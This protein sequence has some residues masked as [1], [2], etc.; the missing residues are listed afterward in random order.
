MNVNKACWVVVNK[1]KIFLIINLSF[2]GDV[3]LTNVL[4][5]NI[6]KEYPDS[7][8]VFLVNKPFQEAALF[9]S[10]VDD[11]IVMD[12]RNE[13]KGILSLMKF[14]FSSPYRNKIDASFIIYG[15]DRG[16]LL[17]YLLG[18]KKRISGPTKYT[19]YLLTDIY[20]EKD[21]FVNMQDINGN[22]IKALTGKKTE[23]LPIRYEP[24]SNSDIFVQSLFKQ[25][26]E[27]DVVALCT[28]SKQKAKDMP[29]DTAVEIIDKLNAENKT[30]F[31]FGAGQESREFADNLKKRGCVNFVDFTNITSINQLA[32]SLKLCKALISVD[33]G[34]MHLA[35]ASNVPVVAVFYMPEMIEK[36]APRPF[37]YK[38][39]VVSDDY[40]AENILKNLRQ[41]CST[42]SKTI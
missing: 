17:S 26:Q 6:K 33:T 20:E 8:V 4:C 5:Q 1:Q 31:Y 41:L 16:I 32:H 2:F 10:C 25:Y 11:V 27:K 28:T 15:N 3:L 40:S 7:K 14:A 42:T 9:Q 19:K 35:C 24:C 12:K 18:S 22:F 34:T 38:S 37:L 36:W 13:H 29:L 23:I 39:I 21:G 30:V